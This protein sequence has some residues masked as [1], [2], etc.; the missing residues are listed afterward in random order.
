MN[1]IQPATGLLA[2]FKKDIE[3][4]MAELAD[5]I[6]ERNGKQRIKIE[7]KYDDLDDVEYASHRENNR[8]Y[9]AVF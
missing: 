9:I 4:R 2:E 3:P 8:T 7:V 1:D 5:M 6:A